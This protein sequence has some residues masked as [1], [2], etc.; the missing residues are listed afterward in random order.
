MCAQRAH[1][2]AV[3]SYEGESTPV[4]LLIRPNKLTFDES[5]VGMEAIA[6]LLPR[7]SVHTGAAEH[8]I[9]LSDNAC[10]VRYGGRV[11][12]FGM[13]ARGICRKQGAVDGAWEVPMHRGAKRPRMGVAYRERLPTVASLTLVVTLV[14]RA[15]GRPR[16]R[17]EDSSG[18]G[19]E[20][21]TP[22]YRRT[23]S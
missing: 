22:Q 16:P 10:E 15:R 9:D 4:D 21:P 19:L 14:I 1:C 7:H 3:N 2:E 13:G 5:G 8:G 6:S 11:T 23:P 12:P 18:C 20:K 17:T